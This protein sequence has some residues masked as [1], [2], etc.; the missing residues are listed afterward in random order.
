[1]RSQFVTICKLYKNTKFNFKQQSFRLKKKKNV[2]L[3]LNINKK[4]VIWPYETNFF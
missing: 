4:S 1:M 2:N 3:F